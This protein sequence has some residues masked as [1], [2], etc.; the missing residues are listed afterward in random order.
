MAGEKNRARWDRI[1]SK[2]Y[3]S[4]EPIRQWCSG[5]GVRTNSFYKWAKKLG[6]TKD[7]KKTEKCLAIMEEKPA[8]A[9]APDVTA[10]PQFV[11]VPAQLLDCISE[12]EESFPSESTLITVQ[13][14]RYQIGIPDGFNELTLSKVLEVLRFA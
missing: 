7:G 2:A 4:H 14:G 10:Y 5:H 1:V 11:E 3:K 8:G 12:K 6:Y 9:S 13:A